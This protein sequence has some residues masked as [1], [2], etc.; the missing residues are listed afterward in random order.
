[1]VQEA[2]VFVNGKRAGIWYQP[3]TNSHHR[4]AETDFLLP[5][6]ITRD[7]SRLQV[8]IRP[9]QPGW[10]EFRYEVWGLASLERGEYK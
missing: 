9:V 4:W 5:E 3:A 7:E 2:E 6:S 8:E 1:V 10:N